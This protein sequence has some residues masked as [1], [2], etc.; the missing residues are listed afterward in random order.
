MMLLPV[1]GCGGK[2]GTLP[3]R[4]VV[5]PVDDPF[6]DATQV[7]VM[8]G[9]AKHV[10]TVA[11]SGGHFNLS[12]DQSPQSSPGPI[13]VDALDSAGNIVGHGQ[14]PPVPLSAV[15][16]QEIAVWVGRPGHVAAAAAALPA[17]LA[18]MAATAVQGLGILYAGGRGPDGTVLNTT[19]VYDIF[20]HAMIATATLTQARAGAVAMVALGVR[21]LVFGGATQPG[22]G[23][24]GDPIGTAELFDPTVG[25][26]LWSSV[27]SD[28]VAARSHADVTV[29]ASGAALVSGG[30]DGSGTALSS[31]VLIATQAMARVSSVSGPMAA[32]RAGHAVA[33]ATFGDG[34]GAILFGGLPNGVTG[35]VAEKL[36]GQTFTAVDLGPTVEN[37]V[38]ATATKLPSGDVLVLGGR[39]AT[40]ALASAVLIHPGASPISAEVMPNAL[41]TAR[42]GHTATRVGDD[43]LV[44]G[45][46][47]AA[48]QLQSTCDLI[49]G[50]TLGIKRTIQGGTARR[51]H[52]ANVLE[53]GPVVLA[54]GIGPDGQP[55]ASMD[56]YTP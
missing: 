51:G 43:V 4:I 50:N 19:G 22:L 5:S 6:L 41:S 47:D 40:G 32:P 24:I 21:A 42:E 25:Q 18:E 1:L 48:G 45:G 33:P 34:D 13:V 35:P 27:P 49:D 39:G 36:V 9:D 30:V 37:R 38:N 53:T 10:K 20:T 26:G 44:C 8:V 2:E 54:G 56:I 52:V 28:P 16:Q 46:A 11:V 7:R 15:N 29:L 12:Y 14:T 17:P 55:L 3:L 31:A 23:A